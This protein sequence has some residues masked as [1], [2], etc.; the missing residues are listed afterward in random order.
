MKPAG[1]AVGEEEGG[2][3]QFGM[4]TKCPKCGNPAATVQANDATE[5][6]N[7]AKDRNLRGYCGL[8]DRTWPIAP[9]EQ[10]NIV[11]NLAPEQTGE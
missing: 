9:E 10:A 4:I 2:V 3:M 1:R 11:R 5:A 6:A 8:C 7:L